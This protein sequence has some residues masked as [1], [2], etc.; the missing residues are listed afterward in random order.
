MLQAWAL[1]LAEAVDQD[2]KGVTLVL[3]PDDVELIDQD[4]C[5]LPLRGDDTL[6][7]GNLRL[8]HSGGWV[9]KGSEVVLDELRTLIEE[10]DGKPSVAGND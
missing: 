8:S 10:F 2:Q 5:K 4:I 3:H 6:L 1:Q 9:E 7:R